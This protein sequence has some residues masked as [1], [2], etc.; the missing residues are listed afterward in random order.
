[1]K[2]QRCKGM[3]DLSPEEM[4]IFH[5]LQG[6]CRDSFYKWGYREVRTP[7]IE[8][9]H[10][11]TSAGTLTPG[12][13]GKVYSFLDWDGWSGERVV[14]RPECT[15]PVARFYVDKM[16]GL[17]RLFYTAN[18][19]RFEESKEGNR[20]MWQCGAEIIGAGSPAADVELIALTLEILRNLGV[21]AE[22]RLS[23]AG[24][25]KA[26]LA[27]LGLS[28]DEQHRVF[29]KI[30][31]GDVQELAQ[32]SKKSPELCNSLVPLLNL[33][34][35]TPGFL[36][37]QQALLC[38][39]I[40]EIGAPL[41]DFLKTVNMLDNL[42][43]K[44]QINIASGAGFEYYTGIIFQFFAGNEKIGG[45][46]RYDDLIEELG[47]KPTPAL[48]FAAGIERIIVNLKNQNI[49]V[50]PLPNPLVYVAF[51]G[52]EARDTALKLAG[53]LRREGLSVIQS[54]GNKSLKSQLRQA[55]TLGVRYTAIIGEEEIKAGTVQ[56]REMST[57]QQQTVP[58]TQLAEL[59]KQ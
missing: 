44:Y 32:I 43:I 41:D 51:L 20:E 49:P 30:L 10:L 36:R 17:A 28:L 27:K 26:L 19:F 54:L 29:D 13:L 11:F 59:L 47:G 48:G 52:G 8:Y 5:Y 46:G 4:K 45:G 35:Q 33:K 24:L 57:S 34:G 23:H 2:I 3:R 12:M 6:I 40:P 1:M 22:I 18:V 16:Q 15:I 39:D 7:V 25:I 9:L 42:E 14:L 58:L 55:N 38:R 37:N 31:D 50:P 56:L 21:N 53:D